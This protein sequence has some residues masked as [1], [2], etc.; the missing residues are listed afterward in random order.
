MFLSND[1]SVLF[2]ELLGVLTWLLVDSIALYCSRKSANASVF[3]GAT[4][5]ATAPILLVYSIE[6]TCLPRSLSRL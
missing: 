1:E 6:I 3:E 2:A 5:S 4:T